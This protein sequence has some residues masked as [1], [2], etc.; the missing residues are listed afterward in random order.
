[1]TVKNPDCKSGFRIYPFLGQ[2]DDVRYRPLRERLLHIAL[3]PVQFG[4]QDRMYVP[5]EDVPDYKYRDYAF[6]IRMGRWGLL[7]LI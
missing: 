6:L 7:Q 3:Y 4:E 2:T 1:M 5:S